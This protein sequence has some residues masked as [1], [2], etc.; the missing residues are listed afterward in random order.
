MEKDY[1]NYSKLV[2][3]AT[4]S[5]IRKV[6]VKISKDGIPGN[7]HFYITFN[8]FDPEVRLSTRLRKQY[9]N[10]MTIV[11]Q[12]EYHD[13]VVDSKFFSIKLSFSGKTEL[14]VIPFRAI[15]YFS[16]P[17]T[18]FVLKPE[19]KDIDS[20]ELDSDYE[21]IFTLNKLEESS[22]TKFHYLKNNVVDLSSFRKN[23]KD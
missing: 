17:S 19:Y 16:D 5:I 18:N 14:L 8:T 6:L 9:P 2:N 12:H 1:L 21:E 7:Y 3:E 13:L 22:T 20:D 23:K 10:E 4:R 15:S 11:V